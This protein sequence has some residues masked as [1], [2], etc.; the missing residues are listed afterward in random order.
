MTRED[1][2]VVGAGLSGLATAWYLTEAGAR[3]RVVDA[4]PGPGGLMQT[5]H[6]PEGLVEPAARSF[7]WTDRVGALFASAGLEPQFA[8]D[9]S[10][11]RFIYRGGRP[12]RMPLGP[13]ELTRTAT[14]VG[15]AWAT[16]QMKPRSDESVAAWANR[17]L[18]PAAAT[19]LIAPVY[20][21]IYASPTSE[22]SAR[23]ILGGARLHGRL[24][25][26]PGGMGE[27]FDRLRAK[28][29]ERGATFE[30]GARLDVLRDLRT[31]GT[32]TQSTPAP[33]VICTD[34]PAAGRLLAPHA[35]KLAAAI[36]RIRMT[37]LLSVTAFYAPRSDDTCGFGILF[38]RN[39]GIT[40]LGVLFNSDMF[41][42]RS[43]RRSETWI[44]GD[45]SA[46]VMARVQASHVSILREDRRA[47]TGRDDEPAAVYATPQIARLP[48]YDAAVLEV[49]ERVGDLPPWLGVCGNYLGR[50]GV[51][52]IVDI[53]HETA[54]RLSGSSNVERR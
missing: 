44:Y 33:T 7:I 35:P 17:V 32:A 53:A 26:P 49:K 9:Q 24:A 27:L 43:D 30:F 18:G 50:L 4:L 25:A 47:L 28:L 3:V 1:A 40:A 12:R 21:G 19:W 8:Q 22:L 23:A 13:I 14:R 34:A 16:R 42:G 31:A 37:S 51:S 52:A 48:I 2:L 38:P 5:R 39:T 46:D 6:M 20:Q 29:I 36:A 10:K 54:T 41:R 15:V 11:R 45:Q